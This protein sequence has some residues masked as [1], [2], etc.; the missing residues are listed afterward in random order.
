MKKISFSTAVDGYLLAVGI[1][2]LSEHTIKD[3]QTIYRKFAV[4]MDNDP[5][6]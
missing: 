2:H 1:G 4:F 5:L 3:Y 6:L